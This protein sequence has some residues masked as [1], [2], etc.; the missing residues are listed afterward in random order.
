MSEAPSSHHKSNSIGS[1]SSL[2]SV[3]LWSFFFNYPHWR[4]LIT[5]ENVLDSFSGCCVVLQSVNR[6]CHYVWIQLDNIKG[7]WVVFCRFFFS[8]SNC[9]NVSNTEFFFLGCDMSITNCSLT[10]QIINILVYGFW[11]QIDHKL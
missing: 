10:G 3:F 4:D 1:L 2:F 9:Y 5:E 8:I 6:K 11:F 7:F